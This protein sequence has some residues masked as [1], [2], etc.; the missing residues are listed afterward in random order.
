MRIL[1][2][3]AVLLMLG[4]CATRTPVIRSNVTAFSDAQALAGEPRTFSFERTPEQADSL[5]HATYEQMVAEQLEAHGFKRAEAGRYRVTMVYQLELAEMLVR[6]TEWVDEPRMF[7]YGSTRWRPSRYGFYGWGYDPRMAWMS[8]PVSFDTKRQIARRELRLDIRDSV[9]QRKAFEGSVRS[10][11]AILDLNPV[12]PYLVRALFDGFPG[13]H[14][15]T[16]VVDVP[17]DPLP[18]P[19][20]EREN[21]P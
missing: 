18:P 19:D 4:G 10:E 11:G 13:Q 20:A 8:V 17:I 1:V 12:M 5:E 2:I 7:W 14:G 6:T 15:V 21:A 16:R 3:V 9:G